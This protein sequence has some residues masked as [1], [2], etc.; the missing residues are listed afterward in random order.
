MK[1]ISLIFS[2]TI[3]FNLYL[4]A[5][6]KDSLWTQD[7]LSNA[8]VLLFQPVNDTTGN[9]GSGTIIYYNDRY[10][11]LTASHV[12]SELREN[13]KIIFR[14]NGDKPGIYDLIRFVKNKFLDWHIHP[15]AD[16]SM[17]ELFPFDSNLKK[18]FQDYAFP[19][20]Q[21][22][23]TKV[24][25]TRDADLTFL[26]YPIID[27]ELEHFSPLIFTGYLSSGLITQRRY[28]TKTKC[29]FLYLNV[30]SIQGC[31]GSGV[32][33]S[34]KKGMYFGGN[35]TYLIGIVHGT[36]G[37]NTG[38]KLAA[39]TPSYYINDLLKEF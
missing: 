16:M 28:D 35:V 3:L 31:S 14:L 4:N 10:F 23:G 27:L 26:G 33:F 9:S 39:I 20:S 30:P 37:D 32:Y 12:S 15:V 17:M 21:I 19:I 38:G 18:M 24:L 29:N 13:A 8:T 6:V 22:N 36:Q 34:V 25:P 11:L 5:Q 2:V 1:Q 7:Q